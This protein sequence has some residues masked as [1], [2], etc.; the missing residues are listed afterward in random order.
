MSAETVLEIRLFPPPRYA[1]DEVCPDSEPLA[2]RLYIHNI[3]DLPNAFSQYSARNRDSP[4]T[5]E[6]ATGEL[7]A[8]IQD[9][10]SPCRREFRAPT[11]QARPDANPA[12]HLDERGHEQR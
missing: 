3:A 5:G 6:T 11:R 10:C 8:I 9:A 2:R 1:P 4:A 7:A 12:G